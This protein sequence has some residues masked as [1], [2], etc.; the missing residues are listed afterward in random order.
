MDRRAGGKGRSG[1]VGLAIVVTAIIGL[2]AFRYL[3]AS[4]KS[5]TFLKVA[6]QVLAQHGGEDDQ[7]LASRIKDLAI[8]SGLSMADDGVDI[9]RPAKGVVRARL[10]YWHPVDLI[11]FRTKAEYDEVVEAE[12]LPRQGERKARIIVPDRDKEPEKGGSDKVIKGRQEG[13]K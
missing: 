13:K 9:S 4:M 10:R 6:S 5:G 7:E 3:P 1:I 11:F 12:V 8:R 2:V